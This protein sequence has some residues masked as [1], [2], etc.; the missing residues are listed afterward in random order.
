MS[1][2]LRFVSSSTGIDL[3][4]NGGCYKNGSEYDTTTKVEVAY[5]RL[6][7]E[8]GKI[9]TCLVLAKEARVGRTFTRKVIKEIGDDGGIIPV[10]RLNEERWERKEKGVECICI[11]L[12]EQQHLLQLRADDLCRSNDSY[13]HNL[14]IFS[15]NV[16][17]SS[18]ISSF[19]KKFGP[20]TGNFCKLSTVP[21]DK[22]RPSNIVTY[23]DY[24][25]FIA[26]PPLQLDE[27]WRSEEFEGN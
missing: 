5:W 24:L 22:Y 23:N 16:V 10:D 6:R 18:F 2:I 9:P 13:V 4:T 15:G 21:I 3:N 27:F 17:P 12:V 20:F 11:T 14:L 26:P 7:K 8:L 25:N 19:F 1:A